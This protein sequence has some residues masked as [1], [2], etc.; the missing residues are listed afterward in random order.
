[1]P[2]FCEYQESTDTGQVLHGDPFKT[3]FGRLYKVC[4]F[5]IYHADPAP[6]VD[7]NTE[8]TNGNQ[9]VPDKMRTK[10]EWMVTNYNFK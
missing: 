9:V 4:I 2:G 8:G 5:A 7:I 10:S 1:M 3:M 6:V